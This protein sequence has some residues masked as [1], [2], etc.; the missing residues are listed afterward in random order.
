MV[1]VTHWGSW[2]VSPSN[3]RA[4]PYQWV[5]NFTWICDSGRAWTRV[6]QERP[7]GHKIQ[8]PCKGLWEQV[9]DLLKQRALDLIEWAWVGGSQGRLHG[10]GC[11][12][13][14]LERQTDF[15]P[16]RCPG[17]SHPCLQREILALRCWLIL[18]PLWEGCHLEFCVPGVSLAWP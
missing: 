3:K 14:A 10:R 17:G 13:L 6:R 1:S 16:V 9:M 15:C 4:I 12:W 5:S 18:M 2:N 8:G 11:S 7:L